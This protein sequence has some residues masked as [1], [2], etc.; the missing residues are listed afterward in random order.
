[1]KTLGGSVG[2]PP[3]ANGGDIAMPINSVDSPDVDVYALDDKG[4]VVA[5]PSNC[6]DRRGYDHWVGEG[7]VRLKTPIRGIMSIS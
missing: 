7:F 1:M 3:I 5:I 6:F 4:T 2:K